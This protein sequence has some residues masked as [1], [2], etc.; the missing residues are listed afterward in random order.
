MNILENKFNRAVFLDRDG[1][2]IE[3]VHLLTSKD[4]I[5]ILPGVAEALQKLKTFGFYLLVV[6]NQTVVSRGLCSEDDV[7]AINSYLNI[8]LKEMIDC[9]YFCPHHPNADIPN[10]KVDCDC[11][12]PKPGMLLQAA[13]DYDLQLTGC[14]MIGDRIS[15]IVAGEQAGCKT[16]QVLSGEHSAAPIISAAM[17][18]EL[19]EADFSCSGLLQAAKIIEENMTL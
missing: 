19:P 15:D 1:V 13:K 11:R 7:N 2:L 12:K 9:F 17:P 14:W 5:K 18:E 3:D 16:I 4:R 10:Y 6:T 8:S